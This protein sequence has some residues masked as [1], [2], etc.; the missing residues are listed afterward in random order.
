MVISLP[1][2]LR[3]K[4]L[5]VLNYKGTTRPVDHYQETYLDQNISEVLLTDVLSVG[6]LDEGSP[7]LTIVGSIQR[8]FSDSVWRNS[9]NRYYCTIGKGRRGFGS[10]W[11]Q[12]ATSGTQLLGFQARAYL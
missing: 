9:L 7:Y 2:V 8:P 6:K 10:D 11:K 12:T 1:L 5:A 3:G 4:K